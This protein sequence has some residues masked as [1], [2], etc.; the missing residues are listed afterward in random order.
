MIGSPRLDGKVAIVTGAAGGIGRSIVARFVEEGARVIACDIATEGLDRTCLLTADAASGF[1]LD[2][3]SEESWQRVLTHGLVQ[4]GGV[5]ILV[6]NAARR[7]PAT[8]DDT[9][10]SAWRDAQEVTA[11]GTFLG[12]RMVANAMPRGGSIVNVASIAAFV[13]EPRSF[14]YSAAKGAVRAMSRSAA[15]HYARRSPPIRVNVVAPGATLTDA[16]HRQAKTIAEGRGVPP[17]SVLDELVA[18]V[19][20]GR[21]A[22][23]VEVADAIVFLA[24]D[25]ASFVTGAELLVD[26]GATA[27]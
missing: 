10:L 26:G 17:E 6:N 27:R 2:V 13:G 11:E 23:P 14:P 16:I 7:T 5:D 1:I 18:D 20:L 12:T 3:C 4:H 25:E 15:L 24:S 21:M 9:D 19:P 8:I 22:E